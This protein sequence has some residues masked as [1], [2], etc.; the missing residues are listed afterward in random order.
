M[1]SMQKNDPNRMMPTCLDWMKKM[2]IKKKRSIFWLAERESERE[3]NRL[4]SRDACIR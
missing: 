4:Y 1:Y 3:W 2:K